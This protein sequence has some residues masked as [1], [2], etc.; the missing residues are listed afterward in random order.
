MA[1]IDDFLIIAGLVGVGFMAYKEWYEDMGPEQIIIDI[2]R[3]LRS[4]LDDIISKIPAPPNFQMPQLLPPS[5]PAGSTTPP[6]PIPTN[7]ALQSPA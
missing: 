5:V 4:F 6:S 7:E 1:D 2:D 3:K